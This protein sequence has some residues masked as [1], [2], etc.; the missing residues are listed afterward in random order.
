MLARRKSDGKLIEVSRRKS[1]YSDNTF[2]EFFIDNIGNVYYNAELDFD[3]EESE[4]TD[5]D[6]RI[7]VEHLR[8]VMAKYMRE[9]DTDMRQDDVDAIIEI[10]KEEI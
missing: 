10:I 4:Q 1:L 9:Y 2:E 7:S 6:L 3:V 5:S 8:E